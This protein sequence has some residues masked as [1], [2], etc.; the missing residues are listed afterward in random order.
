VPIG[1]RLSTLLLVLAFIGAPAFV[2]RVFCVG[3]SCDAES[4]EAQATVPFCP[5]P[6]SLRRA[7]AAGFREGR[8]PDVMAATDGVGTVATGFSDR[9]R[10]GWPGIAGGSD[11]T[12]A[13]VP[14]V[15]LGTGVTVGTLPDG[16]RLDA[17]APTLEAVAGARRPHPDVR[18]GDAIPGV[19]ADGASPTPLIVLIAWKGVGTLDLDDAPGAWPFLRRAM[20]QGTGAADALTGS[21]PLDP[22]AI[23]TTIG[24][25]GMPSAH[26]ITGT[27][28]RDDGGAVRR[29][30]SAPGAG[31]VIATLADDL[32]AASG[33]QASV[34]ALLTEA[35]D[36]GIIGDGWYLDSDDRDRVTRVADPQRAGAALQTMVTSGGFGDDG[37]TDVLAVVLEGRVREVDSATAEVVEVVRAVVPDAT[38]AIAGTGSLAAR[39]AVDASDVAAAVGASIGAPVVAAA[40][41][42]GL[43]LD[44]GVLVDRALTAQQVA[45]ALRA[46]RGPGGVRLF[47]DVYPSFAVA[48]SR[49]C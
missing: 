10:V 18:T 16:V 48:F 42:D 32:D 45:D 44:R 2:L 1:R 24:T 43:F 35:A 38:F 34:G 9:V 11:P 49:Y 26:G 23:L 30:W 31:S 33:Q 25:G 4:T 29:A 46:E 39:E 6:E 8:S 19:I 15:F 5:L 13:R 14:L 27:L 37:V 7:I 3:N 12:D 21:L 22:T 36:R 20:R 17:I 40:A 28:V 47:A 41:A